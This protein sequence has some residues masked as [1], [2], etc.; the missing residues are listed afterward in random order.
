MQLWRSMF[1]LSLAL[2]VGCG[3][4]PDLAVVQ[5]HVR[6]RGQPLSGGIIVFVPDIERGGR[7]D[8]SMAELGP[9]GSFALQTKGKSGCRPGWHRISVA[10]LTSQGE[11]PTR[12]RDPALSGQSIEV[13]AGIVNQCEIR[14]D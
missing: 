3:S 8:L 1:T 10:S 4:K 12:Y 5:G 6:Y 11:L 9:D 14:L 7:G 13:K 2:L